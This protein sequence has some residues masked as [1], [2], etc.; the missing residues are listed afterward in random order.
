MDEGS[1][2]DES[3]VVGRHGAGSRRCCRRPALDVERWRSVVKPAVDLR[4]AFFPRRYVSLG[5]GQF[6]VGVVVVRLDGLIVRRSLHQYSTRYRET[7]TIF[8][9]PDNRRDNTTRLIFVLL[10]APLIRDASLD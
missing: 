9:C 7:T 2:P 8:R 5:A 6:A 3:L 4:I 1:H 10:L